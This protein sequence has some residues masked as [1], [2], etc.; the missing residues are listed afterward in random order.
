M[1]SRLLKDIVYRRIRDMIIIGTLPM[2]A[3][4]SETVLANKLNATK[5]PVRDA[6]KRLQSEGLVSIKPK[7]GTFVFTLNRKELDELLEFRYCIE[8]DALKL[9]YERNRMP[10]IQELRAILDRMQLCIES[11]NDMEYLNLDEQFHEVFIK[12]SDN[13]YHAEAYNLICSRMATIRTHL[14]SNKEHMMRSFEQHEGIIKAMESESID[15]ACRELIC[16][17]IPAHGAYWEA[18]NLGV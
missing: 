14:G 1:T 4:L 7:S 5:A 17:I 18:D 15:D 16:H 6:I 12:Y 9:S 8:V 3:K 2:G 11:N 10:F 13:A